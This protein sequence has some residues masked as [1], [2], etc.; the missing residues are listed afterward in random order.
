MYLAGEPV[1]DQFVFTSPLEVMD[2]TKHFL[3]IMRTVSL[4]DNTILPGLQANLNDE[5]STS[6][7]ELIAAAQLKQETTT[8]QTS[9][10]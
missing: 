2:M 6:L 9:A 4:R 10:V 8:K 5:N 7:Q 1:V 3:D